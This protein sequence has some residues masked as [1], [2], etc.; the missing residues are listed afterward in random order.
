MKLG[1][2]KPSIKKRVSARTSPKRIVR[3]KIRAPKGAGFITNP[4]KATY[5]RIYNRTSKKACYIATT[6]YGDADA[7]Q[8]E[9]LRQYRDDVLMN[10]VHGRIFILIYYSISPLLIGFFKHIKP[11]NCVARKL[12][13]FIVALLK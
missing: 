4:K 6:V 11:V 8:V 7:W 12:L 2:R 9:R 1:I 5:N 13:D 3:S 10:S